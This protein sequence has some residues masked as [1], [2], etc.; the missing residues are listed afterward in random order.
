MA[1]SED[2][3]K[4][5]L[6]FVQA[7]G[8]KTEAAER[9]GVSRAIIFLWCRTP[10]KTSASKPGPK[11]CWKVDLMVLKQKIEERPTAYQQELARGLGVSRSSIW[12]GLQKLRL[13]RK[14]NV[15]LQRTLL[16]K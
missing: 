9:F 3:R 6:A 15:S 4:R 2:L 7:G 11:G 13:T 16:R 1:Y 12:R 14:K 5:V 8:S 10:E